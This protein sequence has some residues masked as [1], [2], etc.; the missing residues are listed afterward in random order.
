MEIWHLRFSSDGRHP[1]FPTERQRRAA[2]AVVVQRAG[3]HLITFGIVD[4]HLHVV[5][6]CDRATAGKLSRALLLGLRP[7]AGREFE[8]PYIK[9][10]ESRAHLLR[11]VGYTIEQP[12]KHGLDTHPALWSGSAF[13]D[14]VG[15]RVICELRIPDVLPRYRPAEAWRS[16]GLNPQGARQ[17]DVRQLRGADV[18]SLTAAASFVAN[19]PPDLSGRTAPETH[20]KALV[21]ALGREAGLPTRDV[22]AALHISREAAR[23]LSKRPV[24]EREL[25]AVLLRMG[26]EVAVARL[27]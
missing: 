1:L 22:T 7:I 6:V 17:L 4:D 24:E 23:K 26:I 27:G 12:A 2:V 11:L 5:V 19:A 8:Q 14:I 16:A 18:E 3:P 9:P 25:E 21:V 15:A 13:P 20:A 10:V